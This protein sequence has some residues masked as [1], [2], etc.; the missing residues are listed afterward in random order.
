MKLHA[1]ALS[2]VSVLVASQVQ[3]APKVYGQLN[4]SAES[5]QKDNQ[6]LSVASYKMFDNVSQMTYDDVTNLAD[7]VRSNNQKMSQT[8]TKINQVLT[9]KSKINDKIKAIDNVTN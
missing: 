1:L 9:D 2:V 3:A 5:Y 8:N 7:Y 4:L 6:N